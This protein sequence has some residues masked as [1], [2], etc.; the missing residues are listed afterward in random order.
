MAAPNT[1]IA[2]NYV[3]DQQNAYRLIAFVKNLS[4]AAAGDTPMNVIT[5]GNF[6]PATI[7]TCDS[8][9]TTADIHLATVGVYTAPAQ[10]GSTVHGTAALTGQTSATFAYVRATSVANAMISTATLYANVGTTVAGGQCDLY[11]YGYDVQ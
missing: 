7:V 4:V 5:P 6:V 2:P 3:L 1:V 8:S 9:G 10:G 11:V